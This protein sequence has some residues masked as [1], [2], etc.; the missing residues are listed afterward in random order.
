VTRTFLDKVQKSEAQTLLDRPNRP[1][2]EINVETFA[3]RR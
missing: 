3:V 1:D 2:S